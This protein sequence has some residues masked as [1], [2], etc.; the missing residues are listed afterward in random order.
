[1]V[2]PWAGEEEVEEEE[3]EE[4]KEE[5]EEFCVCVCVCVCV[6]V[7]VCVWCLSAH[8]SAHSPPLHFP[9]SSCSSVPPHSLGDL[10]WYNVGLSLWAFG[11]QLPGRAS[12]LLSE[13]TAEGVPL[14]IT[15]TLTWPEDAQDGKHGSSGALGRRAPRTAS[16]F[17]SFLQ[18]EQQ[19]YTFIHSGKDGSIVG[20]TVVGSKV[21]EPTVYIIMSHATKCV[22]KHE[23]CLV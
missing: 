13:Q 20:C 14:H 9:N 1:M 18:T 7:C 10:G 4:Q 3:V 16:F 15:C 17:C 5:E 19:V 23:S 2:T 11:Y 21:G 22:Y 8:S 12:A 6:S